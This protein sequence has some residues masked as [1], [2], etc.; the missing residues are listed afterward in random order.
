MQDSLFILHFIA[1][2]QMRYNMIRKTLIAYSLNCKKCIKSNQASS[3][4]HF[5]SFLFR[6]YLR[7][8]HHEQG[9]LKSHLPY[10]ISNKYRILGLA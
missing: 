9:N 6:Y 2:A 3:K 1:H 5:I 10:C 8:L 7:M 4:S